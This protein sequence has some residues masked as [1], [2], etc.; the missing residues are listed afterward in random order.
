MTC[1]RL[2]VVFLFALALPTPVW[3]Q[4]SN[5]TVR[6]SVADSQG[7]VIPNARVK[8]TN[9]A[10]GVV[11]DSITNNAGIY[12]FPGVIPGLYRVR[13]E[14]PGFQTFEGA[15]TVQVQ[16]DATVD[17][18]MQVAGAVSSVDARHVT[19]MVNQSSTSLGSSLER[20]RLEQLLVNGRGDQNL[21]VTV[22][23]VQWQ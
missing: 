17:V 1:F 4:A 21:L 14:Q 2:G 6:G 8:L 3:P 10:T 19:P 11:R 20:Q 15:L 23:G 5:S 9:T 22:P 12:V 13:V 18:V 7:A 16:Q